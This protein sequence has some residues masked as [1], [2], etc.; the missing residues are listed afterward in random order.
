MQLWIG[1]DTVPYANI[2][3]IFPRLDKCLLY[4]V[5]KSKQLENVED[6]QVRKSLIENHLQLCR[7]DICFVTGVF[8]L[9]AL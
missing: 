5:D 1:T 3:K 9:K 2:D 7:A 8:G 4:L 6:A